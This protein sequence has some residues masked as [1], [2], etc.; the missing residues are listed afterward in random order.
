MAEE[1]TDIKTGETLDEVVRGVKVFSK[2]LLTLATLPYFL[3][4][5][6]GGDGQEERD[7]RESPLA[8]KLG[9]VPGVIIG[10]AGFTVPII[11]ALENGDSKY[12]LPLLITNI[13]SGAYELYRSANR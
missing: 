1:N 11:L 2:T 12:V 4:T 8:Y 9:A 13:L 5:W 10:I 6:I 3:P 7:S